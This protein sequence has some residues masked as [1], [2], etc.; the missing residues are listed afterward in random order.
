MVFTHFLVLNTIVGAVQ[1]RDETLVFW[2]A[3]ASI[4]ELEW[5]PA[6]YRVVR[7]GEQMT[8]HIN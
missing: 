2:P 4:T 5:T 8:S 7:L 3:N 6:G 1:D